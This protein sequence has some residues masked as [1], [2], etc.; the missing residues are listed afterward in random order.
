MVDYF[1]AKM[2]KKTVGKTISDYYKRFSNDKYLYTDTYAD[3]VYDIEQELEIV[4]NEN[5]ISFVTDNGSDKEVIIFEDYDFVLKIPTVSKDKELEFYQKAKEEGIDEYFAEVEPLINFNFFNTKVIL[6]AQEKIDFYSK[7]Y[8]LSNSKEYTEISEDDISPITSLKTVL[9]NGSS[10]TII[11]SIQL[12]KFIY[13]NFDDDLKTIFLTFLL[14]NQINDLHEGNYIITN[15]GK[16]KIFDYS[17][18]C[19]PSDDSYY[20]SYYC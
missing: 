9:D 4:F 16:L 8:N 3:L 1:I 12:A 14:D 19:D 20:Q 5:H 6:Y 11:R 7:D 18:Y 13:S 2:I 15:E 17:G 10:S